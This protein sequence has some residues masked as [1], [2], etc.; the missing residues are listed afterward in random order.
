MGGIFPYGLARVRTDIMIY[1]VED[2]MSIRELVLYTLR[3]T[4]FQ[5]LGFEDG[6]SLFTMIK[7]GNIPKLILLDIMLS[8]DDGLDILK[9]LRSDN[10]TLKIPVIMVTAKDTEYDKVTGLDLGADD[11]IAKPFGMMEL[12]ARI[13]AVLR[14]SDDSDNEKE[15]YELGSVS[16]NVKCHEAK[17][18]GEAVELTHKEFEL[19]LFLMKHPGEV[20]TRDALLDLLWDYNYTGETRTVD[21]HIRTLRMKLGEG[22]DII[23]TVR[24]TGYRARV[25][26]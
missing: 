25:S 4:G 10:V 11:Y 24:G 15:V 22:A 2:D 3:N 16:V 14:R 6:R 17:V 7:A 5:A 9:K 26:L 1:Y 23:E 18:N 20:F 13:K 19:L 12:V 21:V 8:E